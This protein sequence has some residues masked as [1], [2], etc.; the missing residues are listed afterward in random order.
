MEVIAAHYDEL[1]RRCAEARPSRELDDLFH[2]AI[3]IVAE[4]TGLKTDDA[5]MKRVVYRYQMLCFREVMEGRMMPN[6]NDQ[7]IAA[8]AEE[9]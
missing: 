2:D 4:E 6:A 5:I 1:R 9:L 3:L 7:E 8:E